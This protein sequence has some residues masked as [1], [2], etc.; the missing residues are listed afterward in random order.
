MIGVLDFS[1]C[2]FSNSR[3]K[4]IRREGGG[5]L[6]IQGSRGRRRILSELSGEGLTAQIFPYSQQFLHD[7]DSKLQTEG[8]KTDNGN[9]NSK[10]ASKSSQPCAPHKEGLADIMD[11]G[12]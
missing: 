6:C 12:S 5:S 8:Y 1:Q 4:Q 7:A 10:D 3:E 2:V 11:C 9:R